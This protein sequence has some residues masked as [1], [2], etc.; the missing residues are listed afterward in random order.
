[1]NVKIAAQTLSA[2]HANILNNYYGPETSQTA[3]FCKHM[4]NFFDCLNVKSTKE[5]DYSRN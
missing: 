4:N 5:V 1:M 3:L 2:T